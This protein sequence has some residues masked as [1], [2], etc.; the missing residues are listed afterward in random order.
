MAHFAL[1]ALDQCDSGGKLAKSDVAALMQKLAGQA[2]EMPLSS[3]IDVL[4]ASLDCG[5]WSEGTDQKQLQRLCR[6]ILET[7]WRQIR[8]NDA[9]ALEG[10]IAD[11]ILKLWDEKWEG[12]QL[13]AKIAAEMQYDAEHGL[14]LRRNLPRKLLEKDAER[15]RPQK[16]MRVRTV[17]GQE[18]KLHATA[19]HKSQQGEPDDKEPNWTLPANGEAEVIETHFTG[20]FRLRKFEGDTPI[21]SYLAAPSVATK[22]YPTDDWA[23]AVGN[24][25]GSA[26]AGPELARLDSPPIGLHPVAR[27][28]AKER[29]E[30]YQT[31]DGYDPGSVQPVTFQALL[32]TEVDIRVVPGNPRLKLSMT[33]HQHRSTSYYAGRTPM[34]YAS[35]LLSDPVLTAG[36]RTI[37]PME[38]AQSLELL[39]SIQ[40]GETPLGEAGV[41]GVAWSSLA[42]NGFRAASMKD[43][44][45]IAS[46]P[47]GDM[48]L[49]NDVLYTALTGDFHFAITWEAHY[50]D[51][52]LANWLRELLVGLAGGAKPLVITGAPDPPGGKPALGAIGF[53]QTVEVFI[54]MALGIDFNVVYAKD[55]FRAFRPLIGLAK[56]DLKQLSEKLKNPAYAQSCAKQTDAAGKSVLLTVIR[57]SARFPENTPESKQRPDDTACV[58]QLLDAGHDP[59]QPDFY[60]WSALHLAA[61][62]STDDTIRVLLDSVTCP[63]NRAK[64]RDL[65][66]AK[67]RSAL[68]RA[69]KHKNKWKT[70]D[71]LMEQGA[72]LDGEEAKALREKGFDPELVEKAT[73]K[74]RKREQD[75]V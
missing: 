41:G 5:D 68:Y 70:A 58:Q 61:R 49:Y 20:G 39:G 32:D 56:H 3:F 7:K 13:W 14:R 23:R 59:F 18:L 65:K 71:A 12:T 31:K 34:Q 29:K 19:M 8:A 30:S 46:M 74:K 35:D 16:G 26:T 40:R 67:G 73:L 47:G 2:P 53:A 44:I 9:K 24:L 51:V 60:G 6:K 75:H 66:D 52:W 54:C 10:S 64:L 33:S 36:V 43:A 22:L 55:L 15:L 48:A 72:T 4:V 1:K 17:D 37:R 25:K 27:E 69:I 28:W 38:R 63:D 11:V 45:L 42:T 21:D 50:G 57:E 62:F